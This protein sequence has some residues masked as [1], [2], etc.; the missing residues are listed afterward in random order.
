MFKLVEEESALGDLAQTFADYRDRMERNGFLAMF[1]KLLDEQQVRASLLRFEDGERRLTNLFHLG[2]LLHETATEQRL[3]P[4]A[5][6]RWLAQQRQDGRPNDANQLRLESDE[7]AVKLVT[8]HRSKGLEY[9]IV[10]LPYTWDRRNTEKQGFVFHPD[11]RDNPGHL[12]LDLGSDELAENRVKAAEENLADEL[13]LLYVALT[14]ARHRCYVV[15]G[16]IG[17]TQGKSLK[18]ITGLGWLLHRH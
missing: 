11:P 2:E 4:A 15:T 17:G 9:P 12:Q 8:I 3:N 18:E 16:C 10:F 6:A 14:R 7:D 5:L 1:R 13:R